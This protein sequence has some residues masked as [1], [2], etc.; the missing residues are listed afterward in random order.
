MPN[1]KG[2]H[3][4]FSNILEFLSVIFE[5]HAGSPQADKNK[6]PV[7]CYTNGKFSSQSY[8]A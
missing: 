8:Y 1:L 2:K 6:T 7:A 5:A 4:T 3:N